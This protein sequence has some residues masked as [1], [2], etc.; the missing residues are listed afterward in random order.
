MLIV[1]V[2]VTDCLSRRLARKK[3]VHVCVL[4]T[5]VGCCHCYIQMA[6]ARVEIHLCALL[7]FGALVEGNLR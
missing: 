7:F 2:G 6:H 1:Y 4:S 5:C 3:C